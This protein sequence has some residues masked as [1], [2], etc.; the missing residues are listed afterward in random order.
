[1]TGI[2]IAEY[3]SWRSPI[4]SDLIVS[5]TVRLS[6]VVLDGRDVYW[7][8]MR[9]SEGGRSVIVRCTPAGQKI[10]ITPADF[11]VRTR[12]HEYGAL[13]NTAKVAGG[14]DESI[15]QPQWS[16]GGALY[17][18][19][20]RTGWWNI[21]RRDNDQIKPLVSMEAEF[22][23]PQP[24]RPCIFDHSARKSAVT[25]ARSARVAVSIYSRSLWAPP[26]RGPMP[27]S[28]GVN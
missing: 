28:V 19:S 1:M 16:P 5:E 15:F 24:Y 23:L 26:P 8:E 10:D 4:T 12:V 2:Q 7:V 6:D 11:N 14:P 18:V 25:F 9:P 13:E 22:G 3:G 20:D 21:Y 17:F 27:S